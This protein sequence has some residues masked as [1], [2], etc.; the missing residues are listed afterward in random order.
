V[1]GEIL[2]NIFEEE[3]ERQH[4]ERDKKNTKTL[5]LRKKRNTMIY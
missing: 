5:K 1:L 3:E 4:T 2:K